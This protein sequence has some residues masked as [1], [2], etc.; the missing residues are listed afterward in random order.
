MTDRYENA[1][2]PIAHKITRSHLLCF[3]DRFVAFRAFVDRHWWSSCMC[4][5]KDNKER[6]KGVRKGR[7]DNNFMIQ[8]IVF[9]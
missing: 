9:V 8:N 7:K 5:K 4:D 3:V 2:H 6:K 1:S